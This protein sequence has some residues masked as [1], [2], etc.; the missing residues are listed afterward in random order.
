SAE[1][2]LKDVVKDNPTLTAAILSLARLENKRGDA[3]SAL[4]HYL[5]AATASWMK[6]SDDAAMRDLYRKAHGGS[7]AGLDEALDKTYNEKFPNPVKPER[8][9]PSA[10]RT[11]K[12]VLLELF[13]G[14]GCPPCVA[15]DLALDAAM[16]RYPAN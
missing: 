16:Q 1:A 10:A 2:V 7:D 4:D 11:D 9:Q 8:Y 14:S 6:A 5:T 12:V 3:V 15:S 13:T